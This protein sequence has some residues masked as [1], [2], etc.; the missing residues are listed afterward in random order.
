MCNKNK[1][2]IRRDLW[3]DIYKALNQLIPF[4]KLPKIWKNIRDRYQ[5]IKKDMERDGRT[6]K[7]K[8]RYFEMLRFLDDMDNSVVAAV[9]NN[10][11]SNNN[12]NNNGSDEQKYTFFP[13][14]SLQ[15][16]IIVLPFFLY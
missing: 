10:S 8:Y 15:I 2:Q 13:F 11:S 5:K 1:T 12:N 16:L 6:V 14:N 3:L 4:E 7:P 9:V